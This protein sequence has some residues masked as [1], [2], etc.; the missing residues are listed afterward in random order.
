MYAHQLG[1]MMG[2]GYAMFWMAIW[3]VILIGIAAL[4]IGL[5]LRSSRNARSG[6]ESPLEILKQRYARG[7]IDHDDY[8]HR[9]E[10]L[11]R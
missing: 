2:S 6:G 5:I 7:E 4:V 11:R 3:A 10:E 1:S 9:L 8:Q